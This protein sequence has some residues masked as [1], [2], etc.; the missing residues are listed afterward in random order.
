MYIS[1]E[2]PFICKVCN[3]SFTTNGNM[4]RH[5][6]IHTKEESLNALGAKFQMRRGKS[7]WRQRISSYLNQAQTNGPIIDRMKP[8]SPMSQDGILGLPNHSSHS[9]FSH[10]P[11]HI[12]AMFP[13]M[14]RHADPPSL[15]PE[16]ALPLK[17]PALPGD[18]ERKEMSPVKYDYQILPDKDEDV[19][20]DM[21][22]EGESL[23]SQQAGKFCRLLIF[24]FKINFFKKFFQK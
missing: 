18:I 7:A 20:E 23:V 21:S 14:K 10:H 12:P 11:K 22:V 13:G 17:R 2:R 24:F 19:E 1:G 5:T 3:M 6:R 8:F 4:H 15:N 9:L 16:W